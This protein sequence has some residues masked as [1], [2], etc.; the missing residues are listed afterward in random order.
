MNT[1]KCKQNEIKWRIEYT[2]VFLFC[3]FFFNRI[4][5]VISLKQGCPIVHARG[6]N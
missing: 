6:G 5:D 4:T 3:F 2:I 1:D